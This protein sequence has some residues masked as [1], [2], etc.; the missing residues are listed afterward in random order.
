[1]R[2]SIRKT[3][4]VEY[5]YLLTSVHGMLLHVHVYV[6]VKNSLKGH[7]D[8]VYWLGFFLA[9]LYIDQPFLAKI[10]YI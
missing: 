1:M 2:N 10:Y 7:L 5:L 3:H 9:I 8:V 6:A 4:P